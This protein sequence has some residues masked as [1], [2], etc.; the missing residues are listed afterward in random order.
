MTSAMQNA[1]RG[2]AGKR[3]S[4]PVQSLDR[5]LDLLERLAAAPGG[6][7]LTELGRAAGLA[8]STAHRL[9]RSLATRRFARQDPETG[10]WTVGVTAFAVGSAFTAGRDWLSTARAAMRDLVERAGETANLAVADGPEAVYLSQVECDQPMRAFARP[11]SRVPLHCSAVGKALVAA[12]PAAERRRW[13][14]GGG[15]AR[16]TAK[17]LTDPPAVAADL[18]GTRRRGFAVDDEEHAVGLRCVAAPVFDAEGRAVAALSLSGP[19]ARISDARL[20]TLGRLVQEA[21]AAVTTEI[22]GV[23]PTA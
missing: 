23:P 2:S 1:A 9:L 16:I 6:L 11:G 17:T 15:F 12:R 13:A 14:A 3:G 22:G 5:G 21:A 20:E 4:G 19:A 8:P 18:E 10:R 7:S